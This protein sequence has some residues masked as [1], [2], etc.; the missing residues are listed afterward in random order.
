MTTTPSAGVSPIETRVGVILA[1][2]NHFLGRSAFS[3]WVNDAQAPS[4]LTI[5]ALGV[6]VDDHAREAVR[7][8]AVC[9]SSPDARVWPLKLT[10]VLASHGD[11]AAAF[12]GAQLVSTGRTMGPGTVTGAATLLAGLGAVVDADDDA[13]RAA[14]DD[15]R[16]AARGRLPGFGVPFRPQ[17][18]RLVGMRALIAARPAHRARRYWRTFER[19]VDVVPVAANVALGTAALLLDIGVPAPL[20]GLGLSL[21]MTHV[22]LGHAVEAVH[23]DAVLRALPATCVT[24]VGPPRRAVPSML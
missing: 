7:L 2:D 14:V 6:D 18:E 10:R 20:C 24:Y 12:F 16:A 3:A 9:L 23:T 8:I 1:D 19:A 21:L 17:D 11:A 5:A 13:F 22:F 15:A 4:D